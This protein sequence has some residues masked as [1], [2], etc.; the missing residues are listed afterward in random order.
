M[1]METPL[2]IQMYEYNKMGEIPIRIMS[3]E[4][5]DFLLLPYKPLLDVM[6]LLPQM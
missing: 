3:Q 6:M 4:M 1:E 2:L 5:V